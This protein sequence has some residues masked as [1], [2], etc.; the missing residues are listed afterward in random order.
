W[1][2]LPISIEIQQYATQD[3]TVRKDITQEA[4]SVYDEEVLDMPYSVEPTES[5]NTEQADE[6]RSPFD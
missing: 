5:P 4:K 6:N 2:Y 3:E 1:K